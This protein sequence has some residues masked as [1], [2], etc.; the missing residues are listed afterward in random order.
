MLQQD[1]P[2]DYVIAT[3]EQHTVRE[4]CRLAFHYAGIELEFTGE[5]AHEKG[6]EKGSGRVLVE[7]SSLFYRPTDVVNLL[8][9]PQKARLELGWNPGQTPFEELVRIMVEHDMKQA[10]RERL[11]EYVDLYKI[12][13]LERGMIE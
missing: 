13:A 9:N 6:V 7:V 11:E 8:G 10:A 3:G 12:E 5:G 2:Q 4:F 1:K